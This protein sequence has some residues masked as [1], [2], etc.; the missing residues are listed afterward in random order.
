MAN[1]SVLG[2]WKASATGRIIVQRRQIVRWGWTGR[3]KIM[4]SRRNRGRRKRKEEGMRKKNKMTRKDAGQQVY[5]FLHEVH[6][7]SLLSPHWFNLTCI[8][9]DIGPTHR[10]YYQS[11]RY[12][13]LARHSYHYN[14]YITKY[15]IKKHHTSTKDQ[16]IIHETCTEYLTSQ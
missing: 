15:Q 14:I 7:T 3:G 6:R 10:E 2:K 8:H 11:T 16:I 12:T 1:G 13:I 5:E 9:H 4:R